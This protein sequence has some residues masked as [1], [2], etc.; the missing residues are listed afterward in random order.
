MSP[1]A[2]LERMHQVLGNIVSNFNSSQTYVDG[3]K[4]WTGVLA[5]AAFKIRSTTNIQKGYSTGQLIFGRDMIL[6]I[7]HTVN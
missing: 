5:A 3:K 7:K 6:L 4:P 2:V 1:N